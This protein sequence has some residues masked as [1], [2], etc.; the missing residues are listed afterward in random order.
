VTGLFR[1]LQM[2]GRVN[3]VGRDAL[4]RGAQQFS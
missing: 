3:Q 1:A 4:E 2:D